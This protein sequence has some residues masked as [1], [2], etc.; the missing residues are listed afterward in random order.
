MTDNKE[1]H[2][3]TALRILNK[4]TEKTKFSALWEFPIGLIGDIEKEL[5]EAYSAGVKEGTRAARERCATIAE[6][7]TDGDWQGRAIAEAIRAEP[8]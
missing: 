4:Y 2:E 5:D 3:K 6:T 8:G 1:W 7:R